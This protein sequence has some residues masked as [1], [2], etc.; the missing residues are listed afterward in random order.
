MSAE[1][2]FLAS[3][4]GKKFLVVGGGVTGAGIVSFLQK[5]NPGEIIVVD[6]KSGSLADVS[7]VSELPAGEFDYAI[8]S[9]GWRPDHRFLLELRERHIDM[10]SE[11]DFAWMVKAELAPAQKWIALTGTNGKTTTIQ[12]VES[13][14]DASHVRGI[15]CGNVGTS[16]LTALMNEEPYDVLALELSS[17]QIFGSQLPRYEAVAILNIAEDHIDWHGSFKEY[18]AAKMK[19]LAHT[20]TA[21]LNLNDPEIVLR[22]VG[23]NGRKI[24]FGLDTPQAGEIGLVE[25]ILVDRAF[26]VDPQ[27]AELIA[28]LLDF[29]NPVPHNILNAMAAAGLALALGIP[30]PEIRRG[31]AAFS[32]DHHR[33]EV[34]AENEGVVWVNDSKATNPH[35][36]TAALQSYLSIVWI[37]GGLAKGASMDGLVQKVGQRI[38]HAL[39]IGEDRALVRSA[40]EK[41]A[42]HVVIHDV[43]MTSSP[44]AL[45]EALVTLA[46]S[47]AEAGDTVLLAPACASMDQ[48]TSYAHRGETFAAA[49][50]KVLSL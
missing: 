11:L 13:I 26:S 24:F 12:M 14:F 1:G 35:A 34:I 2:S 23:W 48:F 17:F 32:P 45:M 31:L 22:S 47:L 38:K 21:I 10:Y 9:P 29:S 41:H 6:E 28:E 18:A 33:L 15:A 7:A 46:R 19:L 44:E 43:D 8:T 42:P 16:V 27:N 4:E 37:A 25:N 20:S 3:L 40:L 36:A 39:L 5:H 49:V 50:R 30:H